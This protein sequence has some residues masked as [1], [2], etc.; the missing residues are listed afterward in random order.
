MLKTVLFFLIL[1]ALNAEI[2]AEEYQAQV[3]RAELSLG[4]NDVF[5][6]A[7]LD[8]HLSPQADEAL[9]NGVPLF[10]NIKMK[11]QRKRDF[12]FDKTLFSRELHYGLQY[13]ALLK[14]Y[15]VKNENVGT[16]KSFSTLTAARNEMATVRDFALNTF[17]QFS[18]R[19]N[20]LLS[21][22][23]IFDEEKLPLPLQT[24]AFANYQW[25][26][27]SDWTRFELFNVNAA[28]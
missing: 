22:K 9:Q 23:V 20:Y 10:W 26:L 21:V 28:N 6:N 25:Q 5:F 4:K 3:K 16:V 15:Q 14:M 12:W 1:L 7:D 19:E 27:S 17:E 18:P 8:F 2:Y 13:H 11:V 24:K